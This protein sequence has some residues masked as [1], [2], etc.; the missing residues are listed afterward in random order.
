[1]AGRDYNDKETN[2]NLAFLDM[3]EATIVSGGEAYC[4]IYAISDGKTS[5]NI[6]G[7]AMFYNCSRLVQVILPNTV[8]SIGKFAFSDCSNLSSISL[9]SSVTSIGNSAFTGCS[10]LSSIS[11][12][13]GVTSIGDYAFSGCS[14]LANLTI[15][16]SVAKIGDYAFSNCSGLTPI[17]VSW[18]YPLTIESSTFSGVDRKNVRCMCQRELFN[19]IKMIIIIVLIG[20][21][22]KTTWNMML[23]ASMIQQHHQ[24][25]GRPLAIPSMDSD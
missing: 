3:S 6:V 24:K 4:Y 18:Q 19:I 15:P 7:S 12:P 23:Q 5:N 20:A 21:F 8:T 17:Y 10:N 25:Q 22:L 9:P 16:S 14:S 1:M 2:G 11:L 13:S